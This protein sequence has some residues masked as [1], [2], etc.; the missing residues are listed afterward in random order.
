M[1][2]RSVGFV[3]SCSMILALALAAG[4]TGPPPVAARHE[5]GEIAPLIDQLRHG[6]DAS[7]VVHIG[8]NSFDILKDSATSITSTEARAARAEI[9]KVKTELP[10]IRFTKSHEIAEYDLDERTTIE[11]EI[12]TTPEKWIR[13]TFEKLAMYPNSAWKRFVEFGLGNGLTE[14]TVYEQGTARFGEI[15]FAMVAPSV[16]FYAGGLLHLSPE[17]YQNMRLSPDYPESTGK[18]GF[19]VLVHDPDQD[20]GGRL[21]LMSGLSALF[22]SNSNVSFE[23]LV[24]GA[25]P[26]TPAGPGLTLQAGHEELAI[27][28]GGLGDY[29]RRFSEPQ[30]KRIVNSMLRRFLVDTP[31]AFQLLRSPEPQIHGMAI[32]DNR[33]LSESPVSF[34]DLSKIQA[35]LKALAETVERKDQTN[36]DSEEAAARRKVLEG[37]YMTAALQRADSTNLRATLLIKHLER[38]KAGFGALADIAS[39]IS[40]SSPEMLAHADVLEKEAAAYS[41]QLQKCR[42]ALK[43]NETML[44]LIETAARNSAKKVPLVFIKSYHTEGVTRQLR[45]DGIAYLV[46]E[47][48]RHAGS[49]YLDPNK[50]RLEQSLD[51]PGAYFKVTA[52]T[53]KGLCSLTEEQVRTSYIPFIN[54]IMKDATT[55]QDDIMRATDNGNI[56]LNRLQL[57]VAS[58]EWLV[59]SVVEIGK[60]NARDVKSAGIGA[61]DASSLGSSTSGAPAPGVPVGAFAFFNEVD[62]IPR[63][64]LL[65]KDSEHWR[66][67]ARYALLADAM[68]AVPYASEGKIPVIRLVSYPG[69]KP[70]SR[71]YF[72][73]YKRDSKRVYLIEGSISSAASFLSL[74]TVRSRGS[75]NI[76]VQLGELFKEGTGVER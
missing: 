21:R 72:S 16:C 40:K 41:D 27:S 28:D 24:E 68:F 5:F 13:R 34:V 37:V 47:S 59:D 20:I 35:A 51:D 66:G 29:L 31:L 46:I 42:D 44:P 60:P 52:R 64:V 18:N 58:N 39:E 56:D 54:T 63:L 11:V 17:F 55:R 76:H 23:Y 69:G 38:L 14:L 70:G 57:A 75:A 12:D 62:G 45:D 32:D 26:E 9:R 67:K 65:D 25:F 4:Q 19:V 43:R 10:L 48:R 7:L 73:I 8:A 15:T 1:K 6:A 33:Y 3:V 53:S 50:K 49:D 61:A 22:H 71:E 74:S 30:R 36:T 2:Y